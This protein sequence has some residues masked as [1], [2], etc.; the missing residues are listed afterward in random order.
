MMFIEIR[1]NDAHKDYAEGHGDSFGDRCYSFDNE[2]CGEFANDTVEDLLVAKRAVEGTARAYGWR[3][4]KGYG[5]ICPF[6]NKA[7]NSL[8][9]EDR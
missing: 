7:R 4:V 1:C 6:C 8:T 2:G 9:S 3:K 5:W